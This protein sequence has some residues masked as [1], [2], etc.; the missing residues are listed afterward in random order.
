MNRY[1]KKLLKIFNNA[2]TLQDVEITQVFINDSLELVTNRSYHRSHL[3]YNNTRYFNF[4]SIINK[5]LCSGKK[6]EIILGLNLLI[7]EK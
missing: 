7:N 2:I 6:T 1:N 4:P 5:L 3:Y